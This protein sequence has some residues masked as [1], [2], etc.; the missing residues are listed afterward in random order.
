VRWAY[1]L[2]VEVV[3]PKNPFELDSTRPFCHSGLSR[4]NLGKATGLNVVGEP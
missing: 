3:N 4:E 2:A 1:L